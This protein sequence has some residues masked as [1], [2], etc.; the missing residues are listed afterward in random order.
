MMHGAEEYKILIGPD[1]DTIYPEYL[2]DWA[3][4]V[5]YTRYNLLM[6]SAN[7]DIYLN[8]ADKLLAAKKIYHAPLYY[9][10]DHHWNSLGGWVAFNEL[11]KSLSRS[12]PDLIFPSE[13]IINSLQTSPWSRGD[14]SKF[15]W[16][17]DYAKDEQVI[18]D[19]FN[20]IQ[21]QQY[22]F[23]SGNIIASGNN[24]E[25]GAPDQPIL[26]RSEKATNNKKIL[27]L[28]DSFGSVL[29]PFMM[30]TFTDV[31]QVHYGKANNEFLSH[32]FE[33]FNPD[34]VLVTVVE[35][36]SFI[37]YFQ[38]VPPLFSSRS[39]ESFVTHAVGKNAAVKDLELLGDKNSYRIVGQDPYLVFNFLTPSSP[40]LS[41]QLFFD[42]TCINGSDSV[43]VQVLW[44]TKNKDFNEE[45]SVRFNANQGVTSV[46]LSANKA[47]IASEDIVDIRVDLESPNGCS[48]LSFNGL[49]LGSYK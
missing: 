40:A 4:P 15:Q 17:R 3:Y 18:I 6:D 29:S 1:K 25:L 21:I 39:R 22:D 36:N 16:I 43:P 45:N 38:N 8:A 46:S 47:W 26:V 37:D 28:R 33:R 24:T 20:S 48:K 34:Y 11:L 7:S 32:I 13:Y 27:W 42:F 35:R 23:V 41:Q 10:T 9:K 49:E 31:L 5:Q 19:V 12:H 2:P 14:L 44:R 30:A